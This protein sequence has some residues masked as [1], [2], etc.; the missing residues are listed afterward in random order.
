[1]EELN[2]DVFG[3]VGVRQA[4][5]EAAARSVHVFQPLLVHLWH[6]MELSGLKRDGKRES[7]VRD[8]THLALMSLWAPG[9]A[10]GTEEC[11]V[12]RKGTFSPGF[13]P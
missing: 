1:M 2:P 7:W 5:G 13:C 8:E 10:C 6:G 4:E 9:G 11:F 3:A 12:G